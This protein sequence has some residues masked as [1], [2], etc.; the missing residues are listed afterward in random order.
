MF[1]KRTVVFIKV[2]AEAERAKVLAS[3]WEMFIVELEDH[4]SERAIV[5]GQVEEDPAVAGFLVEA[6][7]LL[8]G[9]VVDLRVQKSAHDDGAC[10]GEK[11]GGGGG[12]AGD[13]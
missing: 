7:Q 3:T 13:H 9:G 8:A 5:D 6:R 1:A 11:E 4:S 12:R 2:I 10:S